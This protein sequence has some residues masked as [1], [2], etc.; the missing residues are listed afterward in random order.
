MAHVEPDH[1]GAQK[2]RKVFNENNVMGKERGQGQI[3]DKQTE[4][5]EEVVKV[6]GI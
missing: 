5:I 6:K 2:Q 1:R 3:G 4:S